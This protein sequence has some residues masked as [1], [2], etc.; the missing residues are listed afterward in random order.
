M[1]KEKKK[2]LVGL[3][4]QTLLFELSSDTTRATVQIKLT[5]EII[6]DEE[7]A[8]VSL[9]VKE[10]DLTKKIDSIKYRN[11]V[12]TKFIDKAIDYSAESGITI[13]E[14]DFIVKIYYEGS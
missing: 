8:P 10:S 9:I 13:T 3:L 1:A 7:L 6:K 12:V 14:E 4:L 11:N 5:P 2:V